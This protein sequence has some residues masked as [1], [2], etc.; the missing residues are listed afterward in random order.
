MSKF[1]CKGQL[2][3]HTYWSDGIGFPEEMASLYKESGYDFVFVTDHNV[4]GDDPNMWLQ[5]Q[6]SE[7]PWPYNVTPQALE[8]A[9]KKFPGL[10]ES[11]RQALQEHHAENVVLELGRIHVAAQDIGG[12]PEKGFKLLQG[13]TLGHEW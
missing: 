9:Q 8:K 5:L 11:I 3:T 2:H 12:F 1:W 13:D 6:A 10:I 7:E 4:L